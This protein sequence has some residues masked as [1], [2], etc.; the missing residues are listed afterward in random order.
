MDVKF[1]KILGSADSTKGS[2]SP[3]IINLILSSSLSRSITFLAILP[4]LPTI[5]THLQTNTMVHYTRITFGLAAFLSISAARPLG[6]DGATEGSARGSGLSAVSARGEGAVAQYTEGS[7]GSG[8]IPVRGVSIGV[9]EGSS[10]GSGGS[11]GSGVSARDGAGSASG[12]SSGSSEGS[13][14]AVDV[15]ARDGGAG[16]DIEPSVRGGS[17]V[18]A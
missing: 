14:G 13:G 1:D 7:R 4:N 18:S 5:L 17:S 9:S 2:R 16:G 12:S 11:G 15:V 10:D 3:T 6:A 8:A